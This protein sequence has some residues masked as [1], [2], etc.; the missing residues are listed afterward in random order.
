MGIKQTDQSDVLAVV[1]NHTAQ[2]NRVHIRPYARDSNYE[3][4]ESI[5]KWIS[6]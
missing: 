4:Y 5:L 3:S 2:I 6:K 1:S